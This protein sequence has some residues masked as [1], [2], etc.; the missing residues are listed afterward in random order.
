MAVMGKWTVP[1]VVLTLAVGAAVALLARPREVERSAAAPARAAA[2]QRVVCLSPSLTE[3]IFALG[4]GTRVVGIGQYTT[5]P[6]EALDRPVCG[7]FIN[8]D[9]E[10]ILSLRPDLI[11]SQEFAASK[12]AAFAQTH[13]IRAVC[14]EMQDLDSVFHCI[15]VMG[16]ALGAEAEAERLSGDIRRDLDDVRRRAAGQTMP[17]VFVTIARDPGSLANLST[18]GKTS[19]LNAVLEIAGGRN[20][21]GDVNELYPIVSKEALLQRQPEV[22]IELLGEGMADDAQKTKVVSAWQTLPALPAVRN[23]RIVAITES[24]AMIPGPRVTQL[25]RKLAETLHGPAGK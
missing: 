3:I 11:V 5:W 17:R 10:R 1:I 24:Y 6:P 7:G 16:E 19:Y 20:V 18:V 2:P 23:G 14:P 21:F 12:V 15:R 25:A 9:Y 13:N 4:Q 8:P 22:I